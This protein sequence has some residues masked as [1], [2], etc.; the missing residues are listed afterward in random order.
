MMLC[1]NTADMGGGLMHSR[2]ARL[3][4]YLTIVGLF[5]SGMVYAENDDKAQLY[6]DAGIAPSMLDGIDAHGKFWFYYGILISSESVLTDYASEKRISKGIMSLKDDKF[7][8]DTFVARTLAR[9]RVAQIGLDAVVPQ[10]K[11][12]QQRALVHRKIVGK[13][14]G[15]L[16][17]DED[18]LGY[19]GP[20][21]HKT[22]MWYE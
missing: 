6:S 8:L 21:A 17:T 16:L 12:L 1:L 4:L 14:F 20:I 13:N 5:S 10:V 11:E 19:V 22:A 2:F 15:A 7:R 9:I 18:L 3:G